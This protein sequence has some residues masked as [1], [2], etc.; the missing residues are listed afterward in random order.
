MEQLRNINIEAFTIPRFNQLKPTSG[1][2]KC[3]SIDYD[4]KGK[5][6]GGE[7]FFTLDEGNN[8]HGTH[9]TQK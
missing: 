2:I 5:I 3:A 4:Q 7:I 8:E 1:K 9:G 6:C